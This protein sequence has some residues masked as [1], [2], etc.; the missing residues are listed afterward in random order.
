MLSATSNGAWPRRSRSILGGAVEKYSDAPLRVSP[1]LFANW[2]VAPT[3]TLRAGYARAYRQANL[4]ELHGDIRAIDPASRTTLA[5]PYLPNP[6]LEQTRIDS[7]ELGYIG[8]LPAWNTRLDVRLFNERIRDF[9]VRAA[10]P[11]PAPRPVLADF[12]GSTRYENLDTPV[13]LCGIEYQLVAQPRRGTELRLAH[14][15]VDLRGKADAVADRSAPYTASLSWLQDWARG[16]SSM[17]SVLHFGPLAGGDG[18]VPRFRYVAKAYTTVDL[19][20]RYMTRIG[21]TPVELALTAINLGPRHQEFADRS[22]QAAHMLA[23]GDDAPVNRASRSVYLT[24][25]LALD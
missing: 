11:D 14:S 13:T 18:Y 2:H 5:R 7:V 24:L 25:S 16:W 9:I 4:F 19:T 10:Q 8:R 15:L 20:L 22:Q 21:P 23:T 1:R 3:H 6:E 17:L 12:L